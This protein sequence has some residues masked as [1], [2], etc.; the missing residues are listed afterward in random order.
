MAARHISDD[1]LKTHALNHLADAAP[2]EEYLLVR[3]E[4]RERLA[5]WGMYSS[6]PWGRPSS[7]LIGEPR[8]NATRWAAFSAPGSTT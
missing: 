4:C 2:V 7:F 3:Q 6:E 5:E 1:G 8:Y